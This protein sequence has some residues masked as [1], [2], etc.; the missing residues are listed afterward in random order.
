MDYIIGFDGGGTKTRCVIGDNKGNILADCSS[1]PSN[2]QSIGIEKTKETL[3]EL[4]LLVLEKTNLSLT[5]ISYIFLGLAGADLPSDFKLLNN[6]CKEIFG[7]TKFEVVNDAWII[8]RS[9]T[10]DAYGAVSIYGT[11]AN[12]GAINENG[13]MKILRAL[14]YEIGG[15]G[16]GG[17]ISSHALHYAFRSNEETYKKTR[18]EE[19][20]PKLLNYTSMEHLLDDL[21]PEYKLPYSEF[22]KLPPLVFKLAGLGDEVCQEILHKL[23]TIQGEMVNG[24]LR[25]AN[26]IGSKFPVV[27]GGSIY[28]GEST[29]FVDAMKKTILNE[30][31]E[32]TFNFSKLQPV[33]GAYLFGLDR[34]N[35]KLT[36]SETSVLRNTLSI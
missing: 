34:L 4:L 23:G 19:E 2:H 1:G 32:A 22:I 6:M 31:P 7:D 21:Y 16:G 13:D 26:M 24:V 36:K 20:L 14:T 10:D 15:Y 11:G 17:E 18:L 29:Y 8:M 25:Q 9:G 33:A 5:D 12:A 28:K 30:S 27:L 3:N 35:I